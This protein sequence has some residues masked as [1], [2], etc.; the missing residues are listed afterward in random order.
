MD[1]QQSRTSALRQYLAVLERRVWLIVLGTLLAASAAFAASRLSTPIYEASTALLISEGQRATG[2]DYNTILMSERLAKTYTQ[3]L[4]GAPVLDEVRSKLALSLSDIQM[5]RIIS[6]DL[7]RDT[8]LIKLQVRH[9]DPRLAAR[10][11][12]MIPEVLIK[13]NE[14]M[15]SARLANSKQNL[16]RE[17]TGLQGEI[18]SAQ[19]A[20]D[21][22]RAKQSPNTAE[23][24][25]LETLLA[26]YRSTYAG[27]LQSYEEIRV[28]EASGNNTM[29]VAEP[30]K[31]PTRPVLPRT[32]LNTVLAGVLG[33]MASVSAAYLVEY[34]DDTVKSPEDV[35]RIAHLPTLASILDSPRFEAQGLGPLLALHSK[36]P[37]AEGYREL[38]TNLQF[39]TL[40]TDQGARVLMVTSAQPLEGKT[41]TL[42]NLGVSLAR[43]GKQVLLVDADLRRPAL[44]RQF[45]LRNQGGLT[46]LLLKHK[47]EVDRLIQETSVKA[48]R[49][50]AAGPI[51]ANPAEV[52]DSPEA[53]AL[54]E[55]LRS[56][57][58]YVILDTPPVLSVT[59][60]SILA[61]KVD[62]VLL[63]TEAGRTRSDV[64]WHA[65]A[66]LEKVRAPL[67]GVILNK[68]M[69]RPGS[70]GHYYYGYYSGEE[71]KAEHLRRPTRRLKPLG[72]VIG[73][74]FRRQPA[75]P[76]YSGAPKGQATRARIGDAAG[77][78]QE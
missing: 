65:V 16:S 37:I 54:L 29:I 53:A 21:G 10:I 51:P 14:D 63:V 8:Q 11:A 33:A 56:K 45:G 71:A 36:S 25:R 61:Q 32:L 39:S 7:V 24:A 74:L 57:A 69:G 22:E 2:P 50:L 12:N 60:A 76:A 5:S 1:T 26:Q 70:Y 35:E 44:H 15:Q 27:L 34:L 38:R 78:R 4:K 67:L 58:D 55:R 43:I 41:T 47:G 62:G 31:V 3:L 49:F 13:R 9:P 17:L 68:V 66:A 59:D 30:A 6:V 75:E 40:G 18:E 20:L 23:V 73:G 42:A 19:R 52:L 72:Q 48:L 46:T 77:D 28:A 64:F